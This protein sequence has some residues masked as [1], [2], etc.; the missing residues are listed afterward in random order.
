[1]RRRTAFTT[2]CTPTNTNLFPGSNR[3]AHVLED[4]VQLRGVLAGQAAH[5][6]RAGARGPVGRWFDAAGVL[7][8]FYFEIEIWPS[9]LSPSE[10]HMQRNMGNLHSP[11]RSTLLSDI[12]TAAYMRTIQ[13]T[14]SLNCTGFCQFGSSITPKGDHEGILHGKTTHKRRS[15]T[16]RQHRHPYLAC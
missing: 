6:D 10:H 3:K 8:F 2:A 14:K 15:P 16:S 7:F 9:A 11:T 4:R 1:M 5:F 12:S 13:S